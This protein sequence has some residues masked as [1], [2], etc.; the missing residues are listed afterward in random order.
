MASN[1]EVG[2]FG[3]IALD[4]IACAISSVETSNFC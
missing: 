1:P 3:E 2:S 4:T